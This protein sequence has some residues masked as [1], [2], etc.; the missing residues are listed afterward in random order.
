M[1][2][3]EGASTGC[4]GGRSAFRDPAD[5]QIRPLCESGVVRILN[6]WPWALLLLL[7]VTSWCPAQEEGALKAAE[8]AEARNVATLNS[9]LPVIERE[10]EELEA[11]RLQLEGAEVADEKAELE[12][13][14]KEKRD[15]LDQLRLNFLTIASGVEDERFFH[16][17][18]QRGSLNEE[19]QEVLRPL[20]HELQDATSAPREMEELREDLS[21]WEERKELAEAAT[22]R[23]ESLIAVA[24]ADDVGAELVKALALWRDRLAEVNS[25]IE[26]LHS[27]MEERERKRPTVVEAISRGISR[28]WK[29]KGL[30]LLLACVAFVVALILARKAYHYARKVSPVHRKGKISL[31][32]RLVDLGA[33]VGAVTLAL[34][35]AMVV[36]YLKGDWVLLTVMAIILVGLAVASRNSLPP[37]IDQIKTMLNIGSVREG[38]RMVY[39]GVPWRVDSL[40]IYCGFSNPALLGGYLRLPVRELSE[41]HSRP[42]DSKE[43]WFPTTEDDWV[44]LSDGVFGKV[45][46]QT[47]ERVV[48]LRLGG[49]RK[50]Y[51]A[52]DFIALAPENL[53]CGYRISVVFGIDYEHQAISTGEVPTVLQE[54]LE[55]EVIERFGKDKVRS[56]Q[57]EFNTAGSSSLDYMINADFDGE[58]ASRYNV[59]TRLLQKVCVEVCNERGWVIPFTQ[60]T[61]HQTGSEQAGGGG[62]EIPGAGKEGFEPGWR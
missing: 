55:C 27:K 32:A 1:A 6:P 25:E 48:V 44:I 23:I 42:V 53:S 22:L 24:E 34:I 51:P 12:E 59:L 47:P 38:E 37:Y 46:Q 30:N 35:S 61:L 16:R 36:L 3:G 28:F 40:G 39:D 11:L 15:R 62:E 56:I 54:R 41:R 10:V 49:S 29:S 58:L 43:A 4:V 31:A 19:L 60:V 18:D 57:V 33:S 50:V 2:G 7:V 26:V 9:L 14:I 45:V 21:R 20:I 8:S 13:L 52:A 5:C 17:H